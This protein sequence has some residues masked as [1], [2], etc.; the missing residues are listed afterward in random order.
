MA[1]HHQSRTS[2]K[3]P[4]SRFVRYGFGALVAVVAAAGAAP[5]AEAQWNNKPFSFGGGGAGMSFAGRQ[6]ILQQEILGLTPDNLRR[7]SNGALVDVSEGPGSTAIVNAQAAAF[8]PGAA[9]RGSS[10]RR[11][12]ADGAGVFNPF[13]APKGGGGS[14]TPSFLTSLKTSATIAS[15]TNMVTAGS[16]RGAVVIYPGSGS[17]IDA[18]T[19]QVG[20]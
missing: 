4:A 13:F 7:G 12:P 16:S 20:G 14:S 17:S 11:S 19:A 5:E 9:G 18:W 8:L 2:S 15:W 10:F 6:A 1:H 3:R